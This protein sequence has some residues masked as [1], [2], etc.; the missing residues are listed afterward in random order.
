MCG[1]QPD[2]GWDACETVAVFG[3]TGFIPC[4]MILQSCDCTLRKL[5][6]VDIQ[7]NALPIAT[8]DGAC[9]VR[10]SGFFSVAGLRIWAQYSYYVLGSE[11]PGQG[12]IV[13]QCLFVESGRLSSLTEDVAQLGDVMYTAF[14][15]IFAKR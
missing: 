7:T 8:D 13:Q 4:Q 5:D 6:A 2:G 9:A 3:F 15:R 12:R 1:T 11:V 14:S 10:S